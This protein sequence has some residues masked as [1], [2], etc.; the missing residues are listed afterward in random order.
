MP[1]FG[2]EQVYLCQYTILP[3]TTCPFPLN[4][5]PIQ[6][7]Y[8]YVLAHSIISSTKQRYNLLNLINLRYTKTAP[9]LP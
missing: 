6:N 3:E 5:L 8:I 4:H 1:C 9:N 2:I 7:S